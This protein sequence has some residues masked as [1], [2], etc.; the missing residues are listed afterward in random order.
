MTA[1]VG[2][3]TLFTS[4]KVG[5]GIT[6]VGLTISTTFS[7]LGKEGVGIAGTGL[8]VSAGVSTLFFGM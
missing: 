8:S 3:S 7:T 2:F 6:G 4:G 5:V 1:S